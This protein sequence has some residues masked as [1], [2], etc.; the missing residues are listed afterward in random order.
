MVFDVDFLIVG[1]G[2]AGLNAALRLAEHGRVVVVT[3]RG[4][5]DSN[6]AWAQGGIASVMGSDDTIE[7]HVQ[8]TLVAG[9]GLCNE[10]AVRSI[11]GEGPHA[12]ERLVQL[13]VSFDVKGD[14]FDLTRE[15][16]H[17]QRRV[18]HA[19]DV[20]GREIA[21][22]VELE[23]RANS[24]ITLLADHICIDL[25]THERCLGAYVLD[26]ISGEVHTVRA[27][28]TL[29]A[30]GGAGKV[31]LYTSNP[32]VAT[33]DGVAMAYRAGAAIANMEFFQFHPTCLYHPRA[34]TFLISEALRGE[35]GI[36]KRKDGTAFM[37]DV[38][39]LAD[40]APRDIVARAIDS[41]LKRT[42]DEH[43][44]IDMTHLDPSFVIGHFPNIHATC[45]GLGIDITK[46]PIP[47]V[48]AAHYTCGG[49]Q[50]DTRGATSIPGLWAA[51]EAGCTGLHG[52]N[53]LASNSLL[54]AAVVSERAAAD[55]L[56]HAKNSNAS[57]PLPEW[58][59]GKAVEPDERVVVA[60]NW[61]E[62]RRAMWSY[63]GI[64]RS[65]KRLQRAAQRVASLTQEIKD[66]YWGTKVFHDLIELRNLA[67]VAQ[68]IIESALARRE[69]RGLH[70]NIDV[71]ELDDAARHDTVIRR[72]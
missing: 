25:I 8:D 14:G 50:T 55:M 70:F 35:G 65:D 40:L 42:G 38:H 28:S 1:S 56:T 64:V 22:A 3:K 62:L 63:V 72:T 69:S 13:G 66:Y 57:P 36:L 2:L 51:G 10:A 46:V 23:A 68:L 11:V 60:H 12:I 54:E 26:S 53:R 41:E 7:Q 32:D 71:P 4:I 48:P 39:P 5:G 52:A 45:L 58:D 21:R 16:G 19:R 18:L 6:T 17:S 34:R 59:P 67:S 9:A 31:Y 15:G 43:V 44:V 47:V 29:L 24:S 61:D 27:K 33:G 30:T 37:R 20:T 49:V